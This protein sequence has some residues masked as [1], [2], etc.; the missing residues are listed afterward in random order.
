MECAS[1]NVADV[2][3]ER[4]NIGRND[5][6]PDLRRCS[7]ASYIDRQSP[8]PMYENIKM[9]QQPRLNSSTANLIA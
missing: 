2:A 5:V 4:N 6:R 8:D 7:D 3:I 1:Y 9:T